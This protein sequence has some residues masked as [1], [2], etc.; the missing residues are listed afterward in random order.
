METTPAPA[1]KVRLWHPTFP[2]VTQE[3]NQEH[4]DAWQAQG[5]RNKNPHAA[6]TR[7]RPGR[8]LHADT[9]KED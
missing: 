9:T 3:V 5:W 7:A 1:P 2:D 4:K 8:A 6:T